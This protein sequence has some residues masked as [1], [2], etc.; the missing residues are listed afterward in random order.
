MNKLHIKSYDDLV[1]E[2]QRLKDL[3]SEQ[4]QSIRTDLI[5]LKDDLN[6]VKQ[7]FKK[8]G[9]FTSPD[10]SLGLLN[11]GLGFGLD[12]LLR[13]V[14]LKKSGWIVRLAAP[15]VIKNAL[16]NFVAEKIRTEMPGLKNI[17]DQAPKKV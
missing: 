13:K 9:I 1:A 15:F 5:S 11:V 10:K 6:P 4:K 7:I 17:I 12:M 14:L 16:S 3:F 2:K 8:I